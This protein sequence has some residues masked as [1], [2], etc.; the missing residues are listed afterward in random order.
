MKLIVSVGTT[1]EEKNVKMVTSLPECSKRMTDS[2]RA[3][4]SSSET[5]KDVKPLKPGK[6]YLSSEAS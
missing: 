6:P 4:R 1:K 3:D 2:V 5:S